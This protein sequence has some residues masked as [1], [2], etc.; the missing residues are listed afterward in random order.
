MKMDHLN[1]FLQRYLCGRAIRNREPL[2]VGLDKFPEHRLGSALLEFI[3]PGE[4][5]RVSMDEKTIESLLDE[6]SQYR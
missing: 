6:I 2:S 5:G 1:D 4:G 3:R